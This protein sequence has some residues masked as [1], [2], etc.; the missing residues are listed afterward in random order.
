MFVVVGSAFFYGSHVSPGGTCGRFGF[1]PWLVSWPAGRGRDT[2]GTNVRMP[3][4]IARVQMNEER[5]SKK[6]KAAFIYVM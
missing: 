5:R 2:G 4:M 1:L 3:A 6:L